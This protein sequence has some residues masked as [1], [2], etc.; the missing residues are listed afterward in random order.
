LKLR[1]KKLKSRQENGFRSV[2][3]HRGVTARHVN[4]EGRQPGGDRPFIGESRSASPGQKPSLATGSFLASHLTERRCAEREPAWCL[5]V[6]TN[7]LTTHAERIY[8][9]SEM[10]ELFSFEP[11]AR[12]CDLRP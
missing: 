7:A 6:V 2:Q 4:P 1:A 11:L 10:E 9:A 12:R 5:A 3:R 8:S